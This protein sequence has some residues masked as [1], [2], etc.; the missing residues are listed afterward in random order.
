MSGTSAAGG[1]AITVSA[2]TTAGKPALRSGY[3]TGS[4]AAGAAGAAARMLLTGDTVREVKLDTPF[5]RTLN[6]EIEEIT[7]TPEAV[8]CAVRKDSG[9]D[10][11]VTNGVLVYAEVALSEDGDGCVV[12]DGGE[13]V[14]RVTKP[15]L[16]QPVGRA[17]INSTP[18][19]M[20]TEA[21]R[22][23][24]VEA[25]KPDQALRVVISIPAG[26]ELAA[27]T[28]NPKLGIVGGISVLG[29][30]GIVE[31]MSEQAL[32]DTIRVEIRVR[33]AEGCPVLAAAPGNYGQAFMKDAYGFELNT[34]VAASN[35]IADTLVMAVKAGFRRI[36]FVGHIGKLI[37]VAGGVR[38]THSRYGDRRM[39]IMA[40]IT[41]EKIAALAISAGE[42]AALEASL[43]PAIEDCVSCDEA[44]RLL[45]ERKLDG[46]VMAEV[47]ARVRKQMTAW[48]A[49]GLPDNRRDGRKVYDA[50]AEDETPLVEVVVFSNVYGELGK[51]A[52]AEACM[53]AITAFYGSGTGS[54]NSG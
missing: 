7:R 41:A 35:F 46:A 13:G 39:A 32:V 15:G 5:G 9:D 11:D 21:V 6:L 31:P 44:L 34:A 54:R 43:L 10:P 14:G 50:G 12:I 36:L 1:T 19:R 42:K 33:R 3:T 17:A 49:E 22:R 48:A 47:T 23:A 27:K 52:G 37:K 2:D 29:T 8:R 18:R 24:A 53:A 45:K 30:T 16:D 40:A 51:T 25:G 28:F 26:R 38:N 4:C 20:I